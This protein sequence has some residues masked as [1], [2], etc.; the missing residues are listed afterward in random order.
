M[1][2]TRAQAFVNLWLKAHKAHTAGLPVMRVMGTDELHIAGDW[3]HVFTEGRGASQVKVKDVYT[4]PA[5]ER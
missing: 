5:G 1:H 4:L 3:K 2:I